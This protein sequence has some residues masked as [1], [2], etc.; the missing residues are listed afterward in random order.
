MKKEIWLLFIA[1]EVIVFCAL[2]LAD[3]GVIPANVT[4][5]S[6]KGIITHATTV[7]VIW[8][9]IEAYKRSK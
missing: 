2:L 9:S 7:I 8:M 6:A 4:V 1:L 3:F 5:H